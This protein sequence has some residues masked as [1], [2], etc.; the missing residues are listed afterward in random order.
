MQ[1]FDITGKGKHVEGGTFLQANKC[2]RKI[3]LGENSEVEEIHDIGGV[4]EKGTCEGSVKLKTFEGEIVTVTNVEVYTSCRNYTVKV[5]SGEGIIVCIKCNL[6]MK[7]SKCAKKVV[8]HVI[9]EDVKNQEHKVTIFVN[10]VDL[11]NNNV[12]MA[13]KLLAAPPLCYTVNAKDIVT[14]VT[15]VQ[16]TL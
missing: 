6:K 12:D 4:V 1:R 13:E 5:K 10:Y 16:Q 3:T 15:R 14:S 9:V 8:A 2:D 7:V 11:S